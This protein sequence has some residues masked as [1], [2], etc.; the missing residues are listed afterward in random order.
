MAVVE[1][2]DSAEGGRRRIRLAN[3]ATLAPLGEIEIQTS[4]EV[5]AAVEGARKAQAEWGGLS[6]S[7]RGNS[8]RRALRVL[9]ARQDEFAERIVRETGKPVVEVLTSEIMPAC[10]ALAF[11]ARRSAKILADRRV[12]TH[13]AK[14]KKLRI[15]YRPVGVVGIIT[16][17]NFPFMLSLNPTVQAL[18]A[19][20]AVVLKP[21]EATPVAGVLLEELFVSAGLP[22]GLFTVVQGDGSTGQALVESEVDKISFTGSVRTGRIVGELCGRR[23]LP[24]T[25][26]LGGKD[27]M[28]VCADANLERAANGAVW[29]AFANAGQVCTSTERVYVVEDV[30]DEF[31]ELVVKKTGELRQGAIGEFDVGSVIW[32]PQLEIIE[33]HV[34][35]AVER[36]AVLRTGG[37]RNPDLDGIF[38]EPTVLTDV[39]HDMQVMREET[40]GPVL[41]I[42]RVRDE[43]EAISLANDSTYGLNASIWTRNKHKGVE[44]ADALQSGSVVVNDCMVSYGVAESPFGGMKDSGIGRANGEAGLRSYC[45]TRSILVDRFGGKSEP[46]WY[47]YSPRM[48][49]LVGRTM[50]FIW[51]TPLGR[52]FS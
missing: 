35:E 7:E 33:R 16:P 14:N 36:G 22:E 46:M 39:T 40:F 20:N 28:I 26:E 29:G 19:G 8:M 9:L 5:R 45:H 1:F 13:L 11:Y 44:L 50:R 4:D 38:Y 42:M 47:P 49:K 23:L 18:M 6:F 31:T 21:S 27:P 15:I 34:N 51:G 43:A 48:Q 17:W 25:L 41:P 24:C 32:P 2:I 30:A 12:R 3:P 52:L 10:D 37:R